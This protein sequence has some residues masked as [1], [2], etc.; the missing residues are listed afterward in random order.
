MYRTE[1]HDLWLAV[2]KQ[3][4]YDL[5][6]YEHKQN[7]QRWFDRKDHRVGSFYWVCE[8]LLMDPKYFKDDKDETV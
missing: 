7:A 3:A 4:L 5:D 2:L 1:Y 8:V 6:S